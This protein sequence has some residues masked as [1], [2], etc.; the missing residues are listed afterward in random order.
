MRHGKFRRLKFYSLADYRR[1]EAERKSRAAFRDEI[2]NSMTEEE[3]EAD[4]RTWIDSCKFNGKSFSLG[5]IAYYRKDARKQAYELNNKGYSTKISKY[6]N[7]PN[8]QG[9]PYF[10]VWKR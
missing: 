4:K 10:I 9:K 1:E 7:N 6:S 2:F 8:K 5:Y 3:K